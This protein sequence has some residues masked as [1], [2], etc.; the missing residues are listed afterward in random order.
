MMKKVFL[1]V[2]ITAFL[3]TDS[4]LAAGCTE[5]GKGIATQKNGVLVRSK[6]VVQ[7]GKDM[8][9]IVVVVPA[10]DGEKLRRVEVFVPAD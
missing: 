7:D 4:V 1:F 2:M 8:C 9:M 10:R 6:P 5:V 3:G